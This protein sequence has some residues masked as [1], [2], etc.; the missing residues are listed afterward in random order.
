MDECIASSKILKGYI[1]SIEGRIQVNN[2][3]V[4]ADSKTFV[5][6]EVIRLIGNHSLQEMCLKSIYTGS[7]FEETGIGYESD[8]DVL[9]EMNLAYFL[10][11]PKTT[12]HI[13]I[14]SAI[15]QNT[16]QGKF[17]PLSYVD[18]S[19]CNENELQPWGDFGKEG[20]P[21]QLDPK[22]V[23]NLFLDKVTVA[24]KEIDGLNKVSCN[25]PAVTLY[26]AREGTPLKV[27]LV[28][29]FD[30][31][32]YFNDKDEL[33]LKKNQ[34]TWILPEI[35]RNKKNH[36]IKQ[37][38]NMKCHL[39]I[40]GEYFQITFSEYESMLTKEIVKKSAQKR[41]VF[42]TLKVC[43]FNSYPNNMSWLLN[44]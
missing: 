39:V 38:V 15:A 34:K 9:L 2:I 44:F 40:R 24:S 18:V 30:F 33:V 31:D 22:K 4:S 27:D 12:T 29:S 16:N 43:C 3:Y 19:A 36:W 32:A 11:G 1:D 10:S 26:I 25:G 7:A 17:R 42:L 23:L 35:K 21:E 13:N 5:Q 6:D 8:F 41:K 37:K 14:S 28:L 20:T